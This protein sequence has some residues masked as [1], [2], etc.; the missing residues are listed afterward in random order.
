MAST[1]T[2]HGLTKPAGTDNVDISVLNNNFDKID[3][4]PVLYSQ[5]SAPTNKV[6]GKTL[7]HDTND[8]TLK[9]WDGT[10]WVTI[11]ASSSGATWG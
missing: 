10:K 2:N 8:D 7:W 6:A 5:S 4:M 3:N 1:T 11:S 9:I